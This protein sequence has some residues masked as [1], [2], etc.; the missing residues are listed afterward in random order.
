MGIDM[1]TV[2]AQ[3]GDRLDQIAFSEYGTLKV[4]EKLIGANPHLVTKVILDDNDIVNIPVIEIQKQTIK[5][6]KALW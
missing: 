1:K 2:K 3:A 5:E 4:L 6:V